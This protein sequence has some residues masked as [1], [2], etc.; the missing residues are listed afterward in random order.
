MKKSTVHAQV[1]TSRL[2]RLSALA[3]LVAAGL[4]CILF[5]V[6]F[7][8]IDRCLDSGGRWSYEAS[9]CER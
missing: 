3:V 5:S 4:G 8:A 7:I 6:R 1:K 2:W 9:E